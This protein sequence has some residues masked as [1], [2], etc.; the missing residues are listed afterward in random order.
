VTQNVVNCDSFILRSFHHSL[1]RAL[2]RTFYTFAHSH[3]SQRPAHFY[4]LGRHAI[5]SVVIETD[6]RLA[7]ISQRFDL[8]LHVTPVNV[9]Q[10][11]QQFY[12]FNFVNRAEFLYGP[13]PIDPALM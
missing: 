10:A 12:P 8:L 9:P 2:K 3:T 1:A 4:E 13:R 5:S 6:E 7:A 11:W